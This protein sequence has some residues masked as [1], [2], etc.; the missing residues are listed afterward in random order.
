MSPIRYR[1]VEVDGI[2]VFYRE[3]LKAGAP[4]LLLLHG[5]PTSGH[6]FRDLMPLLADKFHLVAPD[7]PGFGLTDMPPRERFRYTFDN[8]ARALPRSSD[9]IALR[10]MFS[11]TAH[12]RASE[13]PFDIPSASQ[14]SY[15]RTG[16][17][18]K[19]VSVTAGPRSA[20]IGKMLRKRTGKRYVLFSHRRRQA[21]STRT[22]YTTCVACHRTVRTSII[23]IW[24]APV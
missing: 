8:I 5:F 11:I 6:M 15:H 21:G 19:R 23:T 10:S 2:K 17:H 1:S 20:P 4:K 9:S 18:T 12:R 22:A 3:V 13:W 24:P 16:T 14:R 7:L